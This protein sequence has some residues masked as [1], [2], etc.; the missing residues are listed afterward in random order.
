MPRTKTNKSEA[1]RNEINANKE[2]TVSQIVESLAAK[3]I[4]V[5][6]QL[7]S[8]VRTRMGGTNSKRRGRRSGRNSSL[9]VAQ[10]ELAAN[11]AKDIGGIEQAVA[12][13]STLDKL[14]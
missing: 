6:P 8:N 4:K 12:A 14:R 1:I 2:A 7:V 5:S 10:L 13:L 11:F 9:T 3:K